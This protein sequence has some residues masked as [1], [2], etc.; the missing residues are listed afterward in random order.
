MARNPTWQV[1]GYEDVVVVDVQLD[2]SPPPL[3]PVCQMGRNQE[4]PEDTVLLCLDD[5]QGLVADVRPAGGG[6]DAGPFTDAATCAA[7]V[8]NTWYIQVSIS[9]K[10]HRLCPIG[11]HATAAAPTVGLAIRVHLDRPGAVPLEAQ[12]LA[13]FPQ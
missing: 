4:V 2:T 9:S 8:A 7:I 5:K 10:W 3:A 11:G 6:T 1:L 12:P 13:D